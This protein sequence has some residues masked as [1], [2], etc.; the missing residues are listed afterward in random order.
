MEWVFV[1]VVGLL[2][3][4]LVWPTA[5]SARK[6]LNT[7]RVHDPSAE[8]I[9]E[10][11]TYLRRRRVWYPWFFL[12]TP[13][14][15]GWFGS[16]NGGY[17][18]ALI[19]GLAGLLIAE[20]LALWS[21]RTSPRTTELAPRGLFDLIPKWAASLYTL[22]VLMTE[23]YA[24]A[25][26]TGQREAWRQP[27]GLDGIPGNSYGPTPWIIALATAGCL[28]AVAAVCRL[29]MIRPTSGDGVVDTV[30]R[31][32][33]ARVALGLGI[34]LQGQLLAAAADRIAF[35]GA[36][37]V[38]SHNWVPTAA[39]AGSVLAWVWVANPPLKLSLLAGRNR[40]A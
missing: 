24:V 33:S 17:N 35:Y 28:L 13:L 2:L 23:A 26:L 25:G 1:G 34:A 6:L 19:T 14:V 5:S 8:Q 12:A 30:L 21:V 7:W 36:N 9:D 37:P 4:L 16:A 27:G 31:T 22:L 38:A 40:R 3:L 18:Q 10:A 11:L 32:R 39:W 20:L 29:T 15:F